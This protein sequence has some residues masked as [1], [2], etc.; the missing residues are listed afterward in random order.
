MQATWTKGRMTRR[1][2]QEAARRGEVERFPNQA[3]PF[4]ARSIPRQRPGGA[5]TDRPSACVISLDRVHQ[6]SKELSQGQPGSAAHPCSAF[7][8]AASK[9]DMEGCVFSPAFC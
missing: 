6:L 7:L 3:P 4:L 1:R 8:V 5:E 2:L 9:S